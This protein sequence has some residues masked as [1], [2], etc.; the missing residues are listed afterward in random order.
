MVALFDQQV[1]GWCDIVRVP[2]E[3]LRHVGR[4]G[5]GLLLAHRGQGYGGQLAVA[6]IDAARKAGIERVELEVFAT[7]AAA[8]RLYERLGF[9]REGLKRRCRKLAGVYDDSIIMALLI[10]ST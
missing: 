6:T 2:S 9:Q 4:L 8:I 3:G 1:V 10:A 7:N 5:M